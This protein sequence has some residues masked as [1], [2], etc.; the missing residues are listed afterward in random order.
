MK[1]FNRWS[2]RAL[3]R[4]AKRLGVP[5]CSTAT[6]SELVAILNEAWYA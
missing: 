3:R 4:E 6:K 1:R 2:I 5:S